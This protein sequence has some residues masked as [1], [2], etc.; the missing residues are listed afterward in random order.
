MGELYGLRNTVIDLHVPAVT[1]L[2]CIGQIALQFAENITFFAIRTYIIS[3]E[4]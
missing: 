2:L 1:P 4:I 3:K